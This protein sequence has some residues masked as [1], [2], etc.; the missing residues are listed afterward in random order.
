MAEEAEWAS[1]SCRTFVLLSTTMHVVLTFVAPSTDARQRLVDAKPATHR[2]PSGEDVYTS[3]EI[4]GLGKNYLREANRKKGIQ[5][6][7]FYTRLYLLEALFDALKAGLEPMNAAC[8][9]AGGDAGAG[10]GVGSSTPSD[11]EARWAHAKPLLRKEFGS[12]STAELLKEYEAMMATAAAACEKSKAKDA[13]RGVKIIPGYNDVHAQASSNSVVKTM[14]AR[15]AA[16]QA[17]V[18]QLVSRL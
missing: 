11:V 1:R 9:G 13:R 18:G 5:A 8:S 10:A 12:K 14:K 16:V 6:Y 15:S 4:V 2:T 17:G 7:T 3:R